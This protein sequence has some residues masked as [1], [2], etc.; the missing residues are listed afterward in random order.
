MRITEIISR[1]GVGA[2]A[3]EVLLIIFG[4]LA[5]LGLQGWWEDRKERQSLVD[6]LLALEQEVVRNDAALDD[7]LRDYTESLALVDQV[8]A[9]LADPSRDSLPDG[10][11][12]MLGRVYFIRDPQLS[13]N[14]YE[15]MVSS[16]S[17]RLIDNSSLR[18]SIAD[19]VD[20]AG[21]A[22][23]IEQETWRLYYNSQFPFLVEN[24]VISELDLERGYAGIVETSTDKWLTPTPKSRHAIDPAAF[25]SLQ[26]WNLLY[27]W[28]VAQFDQALASMRL[29]D[30]AEETLSL[31]SVEIERLR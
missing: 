11:E 23:A 31:L 24:A 22:D 5:A 19:Y 8:M 2:A 21:A 26:F 20:V 17:L 15:D 13:L 28:K 6:Y 9:I 16:G 25:E 3:L 27:G 30:Q 10:F 7:F 1:R 14:A 18:E 29:K 12:R 4:V